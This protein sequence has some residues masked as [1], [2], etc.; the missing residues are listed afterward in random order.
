M[1][2]GLQA[3][4][5]ISGC[6]SRVIQLVGLDLGLAP[7]DPAGGRPPAR[8]IIIDHCVVEV[9]LHDRFQKGYSESRGG[10]APFRGLL[11]QVNCG[12]AAQADGQLPLRLALRSDSG[13]GMASQA[14][15]LLRTSHP[16]AAEI[17]SDR[18]GDFR[19]AEALIDKTRNPRKNLRREYPWPPGDVAIRHLPILSCFRDAIH[20]PPAQLRPAPRQRRTFKSRSIRLPARAARSGSVDPATGLANWWRQRNCAALPVGLLAS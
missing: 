19:C 5:P 17:A 1:G 10:Y 20:P 8:C 6:S 11:I 2:T 15:P 3:R 9:V 18:V 16:Q 14:D 4:G 12:T 7:A 13:P